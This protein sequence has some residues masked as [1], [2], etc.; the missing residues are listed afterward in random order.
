MKTESM[1]L[2]INAFIHIPE[3]E[4]EE[5]FTRASGPGGQNVNKVSTAVEL[6]FNVNESQHLTETIK[7]RLKQLA[8]NQINA[9]GVL[10]IK[11]S[12]SRF[13][14]ENRRIVREKLTSLIK[15]ACII[16]KKRKKTKPTKASKEKRILG[17]KKQGEIKKGRGKVQW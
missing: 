1:E 4:L 2:I 7:H 12:E 5:S 16:P 9:E 13:Q 6:R 14:E 10:L 15:K 17:K 8:A 11:S 3:S